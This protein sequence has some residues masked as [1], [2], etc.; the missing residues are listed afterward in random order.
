MEENW[1]RPTPNLFVHLICALLLGLFIIIIIIF[2]PNVASNSE[3][4]ISNSAEE[5]ILTIPQ[6]CCFFEKNEA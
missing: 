5:V 2:C 3:D 1:G 4:R 6:Y